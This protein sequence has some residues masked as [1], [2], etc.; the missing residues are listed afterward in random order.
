MC[1][2]KKDLEAKLTERYQ[3]Q[4]PTGRD[5]K[6][7][8]QGYGFALVGNTMQLRGYLPYQ[9]FARVQMKKGGEKPKK[10]TGSMFFSFCP[11]CG[12]K[13]GAQTPTQP[14]DPTSPG[15]QQPTK[16]TP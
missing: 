5:H 9:T 6:V 8:L 2:C 13:V 12:E 1:D 11:F 16:D 7:T 3:A 10:T 4:E 15:S 14:A